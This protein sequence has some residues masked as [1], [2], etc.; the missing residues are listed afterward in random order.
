MSDYTYED[1]AMLDLNIPA[2]KTVS[3][4]MQ[5]ILL[6]LVEAV[7][8]SDAEGSREVIEVDNIN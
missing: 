7:L 5:G 3:C 2:F 6:L 8:I 1:A 4:R